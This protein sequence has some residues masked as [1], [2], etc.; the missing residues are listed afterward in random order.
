MTEKA[1]AP[2]PALGWIKLKRFEQLTGYSANA[3]HCK[4]KKGVW[5]EGDIWR[6]APDGNVLVHFE[7]FQKWVESEA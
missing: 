1:N 6:K 4:R 3:V 5:K 7:S 2:V